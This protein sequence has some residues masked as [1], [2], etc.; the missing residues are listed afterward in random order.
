MAMIH[1]DRLTLKCPG[2][3]PAER[4]ARLIG[5]RLAVSDLTHVSGQTGRLQLRMTDTGDGDDAMA[6]RI[7]DGLLQELMRSL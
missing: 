2:D 1:I 3:Y 6:Q 4:L 5:E 7:V